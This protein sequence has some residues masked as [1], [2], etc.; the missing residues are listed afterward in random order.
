M[1]S[2]FISEEGEVIV[3]MNSISEASPRKLNGSTVSKYQLSVYERSQMKAVVARLIK[4]TAVFC[5]YSF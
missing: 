4:L 3:I 2:C 1:S 5:Q